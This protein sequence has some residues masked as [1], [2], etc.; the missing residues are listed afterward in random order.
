MGLSFLLVSLEDHRKRVA[1]RKTPHVVWVNHSD[2]KKCGYPQVEFFTIGLAGPCYQVFMVTQVE[3]YCGLDW[4]AILG[5][6]PAH[7]P[8][9]AR[10]TFSPKEA[11]NPTKTRVG[12]RGLSQKPGQGVGEEHQPRQFSAPVGIPNQSTAG[13]NTC[14]TPSKDMGLCFHRGPPLSKLGLPDVYPP[15]LTFPEFHHPWV[16]AMFM[17]SATK[18][19]NFGSATKQGGRSRAE[20]LLPGTTNSALG[21]GKHRHAGHS[22]RKQLVDLPKTEESTRLVSWLRNTKVLLYGRMF[23]CESLEP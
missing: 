19:Q 11:Q 3:F 2:H 9:S 12:S 17:E 22:L 13:F 4:R 8:W 6:N 1:L 10:S 5:P 16:L 18:S 15:L 23:G 14:N 21:V 7:Q 20:V